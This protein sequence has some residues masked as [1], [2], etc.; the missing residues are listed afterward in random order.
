MKSNVKYFFKDKNSLNKGHLKQSLIV[1]ELREE[2]VAFV[3]SAKNNKSCWID[4]IASML[5]LISNAIC[6]YFAYK[7]FNDNESI[8][9]L[10]II[11]ASSFALILSSIKNRIIRK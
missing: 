1:D 3:Q 4:L 2:E 7:V 9:S 11:F 10:I 8:E 6:V 5:I